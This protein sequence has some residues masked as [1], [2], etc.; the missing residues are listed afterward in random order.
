VVSG[1]GLGLGLGLGLGIGLGSGSGL[2]LGLGLLCVFVD[3]LSFCLYCYQCVIDVY[4]F[5]NDALTFLHIV[6]H[7]S[8]MC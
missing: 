7:V 1:S 5:V 8:S 3:L 2:G 4:M 6:T